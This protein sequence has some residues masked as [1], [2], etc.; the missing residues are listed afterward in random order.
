MKNKSQ[1][2]FFAAKVKKNNF[3]KQSKIKKLF[4]IEID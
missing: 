2:Y 4:S 1:I 3:T